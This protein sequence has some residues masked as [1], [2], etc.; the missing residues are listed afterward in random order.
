[1]INYRNLLES[2]PAK[3]VVFAFGRFSP[4]TIGHE[5][6]LK[7]IKKVATTNKADHIVYVSR[8][9]DKKKNPLPVDRKLHYLK[10]MFPNINFIA[11]ND[12]QRSFL[13]AAT[14]LNKKYNNLTINSGIN[15][16]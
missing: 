2:L 15:L 8:T 11:A 3:T 4:P 14:E 13:E 9:V 16:G 6:L 10:L 7:V 5:L 1:M 12:Q